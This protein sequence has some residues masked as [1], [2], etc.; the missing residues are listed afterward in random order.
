[1]SRLAPLATLLLAAALAGCGPQNPYAE[2]SAPTPPQTTAAPAAPAVTPADDAPLETA[3]AYTRAARS[4]RALTALRQW[5]HQ[6]ELSAG[7]LRA[8]V[9]QARPDAAQL[10]QLRADHVTATATV[11]ARR[12][13]PSPADG[14]AV[15]LVQLAE[16]VVA[17]AGVAEQTTLNRVTLARRDGAWKVTAFT[18]LPS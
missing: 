3:A 2:R 14:R 16:R 7:R 4:Y 5:R 10:E 1:M 15:A 6:L 12:L 13:E 17:G 18:V 11:T 9:R 8:E